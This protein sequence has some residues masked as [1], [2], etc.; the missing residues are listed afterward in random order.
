MVFKEVLL[1]F[2]WRF[3]L[4]DQL[5]LRT[6]DGEVLSV[7]DVGIYNHNAGPDF[8]FAKI[9]I[10]GTLWSGQVEVHVNEDDWLLHQHQLDKRYDATILHVVWENSNKSIH[11]TD[12]SSIPT[13]E[14]KHLVD[15]NMLARY[16]D[17]MHNLNWVPCSEQLPS[18]N[19]VTINSWLARMTVGRMEQKFEAIAILLA[20]TN[21]DW[22]RVFLI[23]LGRAFG[24][25]VNAAAFEALA[26]RIDLKLVH[27]YQSNPIKIESI[28]FGLA[29]FLHQEED[30]YAWKLQDEFLYLKHLHH[31]EEIQVEEWRFMRMRP[32]NFPTYRLAQFTALLIHK[33]YWFSYIQEIENL[34]DLYA[35]FDSSGM[36]S[37]WA[38]HYRF[39]VETAQH[40]INWSLSFKIHLTINCIIPMLFAY[41][42]FMKQ[43]KYKEKALD[44]LHSLPSENNQITKEFARYNIKCLSAADSQALLYMKKQYCDNK[45]CLSC[46]IGL[47]ILKT[48]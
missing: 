37:Y 10:A 46:T 35:I 15:T 32:Y 11:R 3:R 42:T 24:M 45:Q 4:F 27:K 40:S 48:N 31:L 20:K 1:H 19:S 18:L 8:E 22:E 16:A 25:K 33:S 36:N 17:L 30:D 29:G 26:L 43:D 14:L 5:N 21:Y 6:V 28:M 7:D 34:N 44:W 41:G 38:T 2:I 47:A 13:L 23:I 12:G 9:R 39:G